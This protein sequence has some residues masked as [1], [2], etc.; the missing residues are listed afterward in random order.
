MKALRYMVLDVETR[1]SAQEVGGWHRAGDM[2][3]SVAVLYDAGTDAFLPFGQDELSEMFRLLAQADL[4]VG[5]NLLGFDYTVLQPFAD[6]RLRDLPTLDLLAQVHRQS[7]RRI[8]LDTLAQATLN[9]GKSADGLAALRW[10]KEGKLEQIAEYCRMDVDIT[11]RLYL[12]GCEH[13]HVFRPDGRGG[14]VALPALWGAGHCP[15]REQLEFL[16]F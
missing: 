2:G 11:R 1:R 14:R 13:G 6:I 16:C 7:G 15:Q 12:Y 8:S 9:A 10:W 3:V 5:F 4:V